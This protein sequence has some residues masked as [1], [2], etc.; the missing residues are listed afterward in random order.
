MHRSL[1]ISL[2]FLLFGIPVSYADP[3]RGD[4]AKEPRPSFPT[5]ALEKNSAGA[6]KLKVIIK[7]DGSVDHA[8]ILKSSGDRSLDE[9]AQR[10]VL[11][12][13][14]KRWAIKAS[15]MTD[16]REVII[17]FKEEAAIAQRFSNGS[18]AHFARFSSA[19]MWRSAPFPFYPDA[20][21][22]HG[23]TGVVR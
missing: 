5:T 3:Q 12:W 22:R 7:K 10:G 8:L 20:A 11:A 14:M 15:D 19:E 4:W 16:G 6:V 17:D 18:L 9:A 2:A 23:L 1:R 21:K 13:K